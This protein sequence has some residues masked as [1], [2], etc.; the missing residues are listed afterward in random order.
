MRIKANIVE[1]L[2]ELV[3]GS[4]IIYSN[5]VSHRIING[6]YDLLFWAM[7]MIEMLSK[8]WIDQ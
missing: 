2:F 3:Y 6:E 7:R 1:G 5:G 4:W 8:Q